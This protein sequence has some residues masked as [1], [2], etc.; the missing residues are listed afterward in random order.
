[1][2]KYEKRDWVTFENQS[3]KLFGIIH[4]PLDQSPRPAVL[5]CHGFEGNKCGK[6]RVYVTLAQE[7]AKKGFVSLRFDYR[8]SGDSEGEFKDV[9]LE[10]EVSDALKAIDL[11]AADEQ[12][13][14]SRICIIGRSLGSVVAMQ[15]AARHRMIKSIVLWAPIYSSARWKELWVASQGKTM[16]DMQ[17]REFDRLGQ[18]IPNKAFLT[19]FFNLDIEKSLKELKETP[20]LLIHGEKDGIVNIGE[21]E[22]Y[23]KARKGT[24]GIT[25]FMRL[26]NTEHDF[27]H[28]EEQ[29]MAIRQTCDWLQETAGGVYEPTAAA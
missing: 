5:F 25:S 16:T 7:L 1:M 15:A 13:D 18:Q 28:N 29:L 22:H 11:L 10:G 26:P 20:L 27:S 9:T 2:Q 6:R 24:R 19:Q 23:E 3:E 17:K 14:N 8:G 21:S 12:V 4:R